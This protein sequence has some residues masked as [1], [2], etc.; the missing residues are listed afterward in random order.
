MADKWQTIVL[1]DYNFLLWAI[2]ISDAV[3]L[4]AINGHLDILRPAIKNYGG[5]VD[6]LSV[7]GGHCTVKYVGPES[8]G[9]GIRAAIK[10]KFPD[11]EDVIL[12]G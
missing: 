3:W 5:S 11:I 10:E 8:I 9:S 4:Q 12:T 1:E 6:V 2:T 7:E